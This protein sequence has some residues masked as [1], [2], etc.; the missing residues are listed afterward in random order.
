VISNEQVDV[1]SRP[2]DPRQHELFV[3]DKTKHGWVVMH[4]PNQ[5]DVELRLTLQFIDSAGTISYICEVLNQ[6]GGK[7]RR[8][9]QGKFCCYVVDDPALDPEQTIAAHLAF[10][11]RWRAEF[12]EMAR[13]LSRIF[14]LMELGSTDAAL[15]DEEP[16]FHVADDC[17]EGRCQDKTIRRRKH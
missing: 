10:P 3:L 5:R 6:A 12:W 7:Y 4:W 9:G 14:S 15:C 17:D 11:A 13:R 1:I 2:L 8:I 16:E